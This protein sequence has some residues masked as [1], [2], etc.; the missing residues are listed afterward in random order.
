MSKLAPL[1]CAVSLSLLAIDSRA[2][3][4]FVQVYFTG[5]PALNTY[6]DTY[7][8][9]ELPGTMQYLYVVLQNWNMWVSA[10][11]FSIDYPLALYLAGETAPPNTLTIGQ[12]DAHGGFGGIAIAWQYPQSGS[13][14]L[15]ALTVRVIW[16]GSCDCYGPPHPVRVK[17]YWYGNVG[18][19]G[20]ANPRAVR[21]PDFAEIEGVGMMSLVCPGQP[22]TAPTTWGRVKALYR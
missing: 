3:V 8:F 15:L 22:A 7:A 6:A 2:Q 14:P 10:V 16:T 17:G 13:V 4:P 11:E 1:A 20:H 21:W 18:N 9:C 12:S 5:N 19:G